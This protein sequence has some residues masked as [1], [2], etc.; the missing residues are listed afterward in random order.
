MK[1]SRVFATHLMSDSPRKSLLSLLSSSL[2]NIFTPCVIIVASLFTCAILVARYALPTRMIIVLDKGLREVEDL[3]YDMCG[4]YRLNLAEAENDLAARLIAIEDEAASLRI[5]FLRL[6]HAPGMA[7]WSE[8][9][10]F[11]M[12]HSLAIWLCTS[13][14]CALQRDLLLR[15]QQKMQALHAEFAAGNSPVWQLRMRQR[16]CSN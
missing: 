6:T 15:Q 2:S 8:C 9:R 7:W 13:K 10:G 14:I 12:G 16:Y 5:R 4:A 11:F 1:T 3:Y